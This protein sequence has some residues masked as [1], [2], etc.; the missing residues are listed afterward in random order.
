MTTTRLAMMFLL[1]AV[2]FAAQA[3]GALP[4]QIAA[5]VPQGTRLTSQSFTGTPTIAVAEFTAKKIVDVGRTIEYRL[6]IRA[7]DNNSPTWKMRESAYRKQMEL[8][9]EQNRKNLSPESA[10]QGMFTADPVKEATNAWGTSL[11]QRVLNHPPQAKQFISYQCAYFGMVGGVVFELFVS[12]IPDR[13]D[14][15]NQ[16]AQMVANAA[17][18]LSV[19]N[20]GDK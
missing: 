8:R 13:P 11:T 2:A 17:S 4:A 7:L 1:P 3:S 6:V 12:G 18:K 9:I 5:L 16:W 14:V 19:S 20:I 10:N 15:A